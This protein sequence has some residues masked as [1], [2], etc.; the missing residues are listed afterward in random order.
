MDTS[1][2]ADSRRIGQGKPGPGRP[3]AAP[4]RATIAIREM[5]LAA[6][7][8]VGGADYLAEQAR[9]NP[10]AFAGLVR[11]ALPGRATAPEAHIERWAP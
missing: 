8:Q 10:T 2:T 6:L 4:N 11:R 3:P 5:I 1:P 7:E 9:V